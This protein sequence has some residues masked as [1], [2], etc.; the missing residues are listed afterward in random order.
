MHYAALYR[1]LLTQEPQVD[2]AQFLTPAGSSSSSRRADS[3]RSSSVSSLFS[4]EIAGAVS[5]SSYGLVNY[6]FHRKSSYWSVPSPHV[7]FS[8]LGLFVYSLGFSVLLLTQLVRFAWST[9]Q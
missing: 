2:F 6:G 3:L 4:C 1:H 9:Q 5:S 8:N 7:V